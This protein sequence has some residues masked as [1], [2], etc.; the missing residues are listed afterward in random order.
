MM[1]FIA[2]S[3]LCCFSIFLQ[4]FESHAQFLIVD[5]L[6]KLALHKVVVA[7]CVEEPLLHVLIAGQSG[8]SEVL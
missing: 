2:D 1:Y 5:A 3:Y 8:S 4:K 7:M 6:L